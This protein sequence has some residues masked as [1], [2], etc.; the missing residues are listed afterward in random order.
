[1]VLYLLCHA[2]EGDAVLCDDMEHVPVL[3]VRHAAAQTVMAVMSG[4]GGGGGD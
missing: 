1:M 2:H 3:C 4:S